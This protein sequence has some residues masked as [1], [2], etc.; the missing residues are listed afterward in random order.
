MAR[1]EKSKVRVVYF[2][3]EAGDRT[4]EDS[5][6]SIVNALGGARPQLR[7]G[8]ASLP[9]HAVVTSIDDADA[10]EVIEEEEAPKRSARTSGKRKVKTPVV[11]N[12][13]GFDTASVTLADFADGYKVE[14]DQSKYLL[15]VEWFRSYGDKQSVN[16]DHL[17]NAYKSMGW[18][19][20]DEPS[21]P[22]RRLK[23]LQWLD[24]SDG[25]Y[26]MNHIGEKKLARLKA[27]A[28][29]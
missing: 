8:A 4:L 17:Y 27:S 9:R 3:M 11:M 13:L 29:E 5:I 25:N 23:S 12:D 21:K 26:S 20:P 1:E 14:S 16:S 7:N 10:E 2:E 6:K 24:G 22:L 19:V 15:I 18:T 28:A